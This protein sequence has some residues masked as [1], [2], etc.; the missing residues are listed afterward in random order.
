MATIFHH[1]HS[2]LTKKFRKTKTNELT[3]FREYIYHGQYSEDN[4][5]LKES[6]NSI[7]EFFKK[8]L[9]DEGAVVMESKFNGYYYPFFD[10]DSFGKMELFKN[11]Y[12]QDHLLGRGVSYVIFKSSD[13]HY[14]GILDEPTKNL[15]DIFL[16][17]NWKGCNDSSY[18][19]YS[20][21]QK[22][23]FIRGIYENESRKPRLYETSGTLSKNFQL[24]I[25]TLV[26]YYNREGL[27][28]SV[29]RY[30]EPTM[31]IKFNRKIKLRKIN[32]K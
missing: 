17:H 21:E 12:D 20:K 9:K 13:D 3:F 29:L 30:K 14:W 10:L 23:L 22:N 1:L 7:I 32:G 2:Y 16:D 24:F 25:N 4:M 18:I 15:E 5:L 28:L 8:N 27:E 11:L 26:R 6:L 19:R 31:L